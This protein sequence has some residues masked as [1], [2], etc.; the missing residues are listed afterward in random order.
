MDELLQGQAHFGQRKR[1]HL[2]GPSATKQDRER[3]RSGEETSKGR[4]RWVKGLLRWAMGRLRKA[5]GMSK[6]AKGMSI[7]ASGKFNSDSGRFR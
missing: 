5:K 6:M 1:R 4:W 2:E 3:K 7:T